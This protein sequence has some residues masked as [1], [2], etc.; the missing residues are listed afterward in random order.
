M[1]SVLKD[2]YISNKVISVEKKHFVGDSEPH[3][4]EFF[5]IEYVV[6]GNGIC[7]VDGRPYPLTGNSLFVLTHANTH[8]I[9]N[10]DA[11]LITV[12][13]KGEYE[14]ELLCL[15]VISSIGN[16]AFELDATDR[17][18]VFSILNEIYEVHTTNIKYAMLL[19]QCIL[20]KLTYYP[21]KGSREYIPYI[22]S[23]ILYMTQ[24]FR[25]GVT[26]ERTAG[27]L[28][29]SSAYLSDIFVKHTGINFKAYLN[30]LQFSH[31]RNLLAC[32]DL[33]IGEI[34]KYSGF[35]DYSNFSRRFKKI[36][37]A[38][39]SEYRNSLRKKQEK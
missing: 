5:E 8:A 20:Q 12:M 25:D 29:L 13:F 21:C 14:D 32:T 38:T 18:L 1:L 17:E 6:S 24:N 4:H 33:P 36:F 23:A 27:H 31:A 2:A 3:I 16:P 30:N 7:E 10:A 35:A 28:G 11:E 26:L 15:P 9:K 39:P 34:H 19:L 22:Q 37:G